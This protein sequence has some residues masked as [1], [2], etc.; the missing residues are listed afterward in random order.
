MMS[1]KYVASLVTLLCGCSVLVPR[2]AQKAAGTHYSAAFA[3]NQALFVFPLSRGKELRV[4]LASSL[5]LPVYSAN[6]RVIYGLVNQPGGL[7]DLVAVRLKPSGITVLPGSGRFSLISGLA[8]NASET[9]AIISAR[10][11]S[12]PARPC[13]VFEIDFKT[14]DIAQVA[15]NA[16]PGCGYLAAWTHLSL[17]P[18][19]R[20]AVG[21]TGKGRLGLI[22]LK[23]RRI[24]K[25][26]VGTTASWSP[27]GRWIAATTF[28]SPMEIELLDALTGAKRRSL[29]SDVTGELQWSPDSRYL[30]VSGNSLCG[31]FTGYA[32]TLAALDIESAERFTIGSSRCRVSLMTTGWVSDEVFE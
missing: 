30:L 2:E 32:G 3:Q 22:N 19:G 24:T 27:D 31:L 11:E 9:L 20:F 16:V 28:E 21:T 1:R 7:S 6:G 4:S 18:D 12:D 15:G 23:E 29:G 26:W 25:L 14:G 17:S 10:Y 13:G 5:G 8:V